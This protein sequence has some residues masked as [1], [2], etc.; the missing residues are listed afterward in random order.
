MVEEEAVTVGGVDT[1]VGED[2]V[3]ILMVVGTEVHSCPSL[4][5]RAF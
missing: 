1:E 5:I 4:L 3:E 2:T